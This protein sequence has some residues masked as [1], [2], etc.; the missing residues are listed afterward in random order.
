VRS[1]NTGLKSSGK[2]GRLKSAA[3]M[4][5]PLVNAVSLMFFVQF[6]GYNVSS[7]YAASILQESIL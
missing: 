1:Q 7:L 3:M 6:G 4:Y 5:R 2:L